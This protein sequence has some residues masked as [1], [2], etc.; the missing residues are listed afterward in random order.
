MVMG[1]V[2]AGPPKRGDPTPKEAG[3][4]RDKALG[5]IRRDNRDRRDKRDGRDEAD[6]L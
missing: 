6:S 2:A 1:M 5:G 4:T 3:L